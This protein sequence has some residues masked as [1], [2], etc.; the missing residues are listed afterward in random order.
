MNGEDIR[1]FTLRTGEVSTGPITMKHIRRAVRVAGGDNP[2]AAGMDVAAV[3]LAGLL[4]DAGHMPAEV[5]RLSAEEKADWA[6]DQV[7]PGQI[8]AVIDEIA[9]ALQALTGGATEPGEA[10]AP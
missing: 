2:L 8:T 1:T 3:V 7:L 5:A 10:P 6:C 9:P 4:E